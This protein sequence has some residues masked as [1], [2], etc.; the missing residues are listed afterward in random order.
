MSKAQNI[1]EVVNLND[2]VKILKENEKKFV[3]VGL[4]L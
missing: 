2:L 1:W 4:C 3:I